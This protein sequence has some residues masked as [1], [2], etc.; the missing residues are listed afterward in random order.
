[1]DSS[2][3]GVQTCALPI[4]GFCT[5]QNPHLP[6]PS[7]SPIH[8]FTHMLPIHPGHL[9]TYSPIHLFTYSPFHS[10]AHHSSSSPVTQPIFPSAIPA[11]VEKHSKRD[12]GGDRRGDKIVRQAS[13]NTTQ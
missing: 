7:Y 12:R 2:V 5:I 1:R 13:N 8:P 10:H 4:L 6:K 9:F 11:R 3:T